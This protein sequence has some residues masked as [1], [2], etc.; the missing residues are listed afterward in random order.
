MR[1]CVNA[2]N[3]KLGQATSRPRRFG[4]R[5]QAKARGPG[6]TPLFLTAPKAVSRG[7]P[8]LPRHSTA[9]AKAGAT[10]LQSFRHPSSL[11][12]V[13][14]VLFVVKKFQVAI[15]LI[16]RQARI[17]RGARS[18]LAFAHFSSRLGSASPWRGV[19]FEHSR[20]RA[21]LFPPRVCLALARGF[22]HAFEHSRI[23]AFLKLPIPH[24]P[25][26][27]KP[28]EQRGLQAAHPIRAG[29]CEIDA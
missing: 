9:G 29:A 27:A 25:Q 20:I 4:V 15:R 5:W 2:R 18:I 14:F 23:R 12:F 17:A 26:L 21:F 28:K 13:Y 11:I 22:I 6:A 19:S 1:E 16:A 24:H 7:I 8:L 3:L 10:A